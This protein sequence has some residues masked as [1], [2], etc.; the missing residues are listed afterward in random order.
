MFISKDLLEFFGS[1]KEIKKQKRDV[2]Y[3]LAKE[4]EDLEIR[5]TLVDIGLNE[6]QQINRL[7]QSMVLVNG[8][9]V[10]ALDDDDRPEPVFPPKSA[11]EQVG[12][13]SGGATAGS[14]PGKKGGTGAVPAETVKRSEPVVP[15]RSVPTAPVK[16]EVV[17]PQPVKPD[18]VVA[19]GVSGNE[20]VPPAAPAEG[21]AAEPGS[22]S[23]VALK[24]VV[25]PVVE[26]TP[27]AAKVPAVEPEVAAAG[28]V[29][30]VEDETFESYGTS[31]AAGTVVAPIGGARPGPGLLPP[32][33]QLKM[34]GSDSLT[35]QSELMTLPINPLSEVF[36]FAT[37]NPSAKARRYRSNRRCPFNNRVPN[38]TRHQTGNPLGV[39]SINHQ[40]GTVITCPVRLREDWL[41]TEDAA[42]FFFRES[43]HWS[44]LTDVE[45]TDAAG[46]SAGTFDVVLVAYDD[47]GK[48]ADFGAIELQAAAVGGDL[49]H[50]FERYME[51]PEANASMDWRDKPSY[52]VPDFVTARREGLVPQLIYKHAILNSWN[53]KLAIA[54]DRQFFESLE[55]LVTVEKESAD[56]AWILYDLDRSGSGEQASLSLTKCGVAYT[57]Y[58]QSLAALTSTAPDDIANF[59]R[60]LPELAGR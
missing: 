8:G 45:L 15:K 41:V 21:T 51:N 52:P 4:V 2:F 25:M 18:A 53:K 35:Q 28:A 48:I 59:M 16:P 32:H 29:E 13:A 5:K 27:D 37:E 26:P 3:Q 36:G 6:Q 10:P 23:G 9:D 56:I 46:K 22:D 55:G 19:G 7:H 40:D 49:H 43:A 1:M 17:K 34:S 33:V 31:T 58:S 60:M 44:S 14:T 24:P 54:I 30:S 50:P 38:C 11:V 42:S 39:C 20:A 47:Q 12:S 57:N